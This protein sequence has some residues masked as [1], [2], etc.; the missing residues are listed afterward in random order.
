[1]SRRRPAL[2]S[3]RGLAGGLGLLAA[4]IVGLAL[5]PDFG[6]E[7]D[8]APPAVLNRIAA[9]NDRAAVEAAA[10]MRSESEASARAAD[11]RSAAAESVA[12]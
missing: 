5:A 6:R 4:L 2:V 1:M 10:R 8:G 12:E 3:R 9:K 7:A 11:A